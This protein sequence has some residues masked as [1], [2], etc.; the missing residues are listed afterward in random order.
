MKRIVILDAYSTVHVGNG[1]L[2]E[3]SLKVCEKAYPGAQVSILTLDTKTNEKRYKNL[4]LTLFGTFAV[5]QG[6]LKQIVWGIQQVLFMFFQTANIFTLKINPNKIAFNK[7]HKNAMQVINEADICISITGEALND[8]FQKALYFWLFSYWMV[9]KYNKK[10]VIFPQSIGPLDKKINKFLVHFALK[11]ASLLVGRDQKSYQKLVELGFD[12]RQIMYSPDVAILQEI[13]E[14]YNISQYFDTTNDKKIIGITVSKIHGEITT[15]QDYVGS[16][17][18][19]V[20]NMLNPNEYKI[21]LMPSNY[22]QDSISPDYALCQRVQSKLGVTFETSIL[23]LNPLFPGDYK[24][25]LCQLEVFITTRMHV[26]ILSTS[27]YIPTIAINTQH[28]IRGYMKNIGMED[29]CLDFK[30]L[31]KLDKVLKKSLTEN[32]HIRKSLEENLVGV[33]NDLNLFITRF[34]EI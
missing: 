7:D 31:D 24:A 18:E 28:K 6:K 25:L 21:L 20:I 17:I 34:G 26:G 9:I 5:K 23:T 32:K 30:D 10:L 29:Y 2:L 3:N 4:N 16:V 22:Y 11:N 1:A 15:E 13:N 19:S 8:N 27:G 14:S 12:E 33:H